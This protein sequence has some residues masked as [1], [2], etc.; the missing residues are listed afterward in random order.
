MANYSSVGWYDWD[1][2]CD[3]WDR[4]QW[5]RFAPLNISTASVMAADYSPVPVEPTISYPKQPVPVA[6]SPI[7]FPRP[8]PVA[9]APMPS[10]VAPSPPTIGL[11]RAF[12]QQAGWD[13]RFVGGPATQRYFPK[14]DAAKKAAYEQKRGGSTGMSGLG[15]TPWYED[16]R[17][18]G[19]GLGELAGC[20]K[21]KIQVYIQQPESSGFEISPWAIWIAVGALIFIAVKKR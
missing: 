15:C 18:G 14:I 9:P 1:T 17:L 5:L 8:V 21:D 4:L 10:P 16:D 6:P 19:P 3:E 7:P 20:G 11:P 2:E 13:N 12:Q